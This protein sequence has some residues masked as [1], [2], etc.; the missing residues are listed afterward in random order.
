[1]TRIRRLRPV[2]IRAG[3]MGCLA[4][5]CGTVG[6][7]APAVADDADSE[8]ANRLEALRGRIDPLIGGENFLDTLHFGW[9]D[10]PYARATLAVLTKTT[11]TLEREGRLRQQ[12]NGALLVT[13]TRDI[14]TWAEKAIERVYEPEP[15]LGFRPHRLRVAGPAFATDDSS[16]VLF[17]FVDAATATQNDPV[18]GDLDLLLSLGFR[19]Y[20]RAAGSSHTRAFGA[21]LRERART[22][23]AATVAVTMGGGGSSQTSGTRGEAD[24]MVQSMT[25]ARLLDA[26]PESTGDARLAMAVVDPPLRESWACSLARRALARGM[27][28]RSRYFSDGWLPP[29][30]VEVDTDAIAAAMWV[31]ALEGQSLG[32]IRGWRDLRDGST[33]PNKSML[34]HP[35]SVETI[36]KTALDLIRLHDGVIPFHSTPALALV[37]GPDAIDPN[38]M[39]AWADWTRPVCDGLF[40]RGIRYDVLSTR[41]AQGKRRERYAVVYPLSRTATSDIPALVST[42]EGLLEAAGVEPE[43]VR[44]AVADAKWQGALY[45]RSEQSSDGLL[46][47]AL[48]NLSDDPCRVTLTDI[49]HHG[50]WRDLVSDQLVRDPSAAISLEPWQVR[51]LRQQD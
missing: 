41:A 31:H 33:T 24:L 11:A 38:D 45:Q 37:V 8:F 16:V 27:S 3:A 47:V 13:Q 14:F 26:A 10:R 42:V 25:L 6:V 39:N 35:R 5:L 15:E 22:L 43:P 12:G 20:A 48:V 1:M 4:L 7:A 2:R 9:F 18:Y 50:A 49:S 29:S 40:D 46:H 34:I 23:G 32:L 30:R 36:A 51:L 19:V 17:A 44:A 28:G 21:T